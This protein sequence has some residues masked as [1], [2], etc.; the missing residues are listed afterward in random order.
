MFVNYFAINCPN[1]YSPSLTN[2]NVIGSFFTE[3][4][5]VS[6]IVCLQSK[7]REKSIFKKF[8]K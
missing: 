8:S 3:V 2:N 5:I 1:G 6:V 4:T 7:E